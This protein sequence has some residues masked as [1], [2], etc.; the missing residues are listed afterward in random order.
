M[1]KIF[2]TGASGNVGKTIVRTARTM[3]DFEL[4]GGWCAEAGLDIG[5]LA[6]IEP[7]G[8]KI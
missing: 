6:G 1:I 4:A 2:V 3:D 5:S 7:L 8:I